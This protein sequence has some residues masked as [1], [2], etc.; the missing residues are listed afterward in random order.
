MIFY[1]IVSIA[2]ALRVFFIGHHDL[3]AEEA[4]YWNY[5]MHLDWSY[6]DHPV[7]VALLI[8]LS[9]IL[10]GLTEF[11][12]RFPAFICWGIAMYYSYQWSEL[13]QRGCGPY[14]VLL[15]SILPFF[16][17]YSLIIT[18]D[19]PLIACWSA[20]LYYLYRALCRH[21]KRAW[22][23]AGIAIGLGL[24]SKYTMVLVIATT[25]LY[26]LTVPTARVWLRQK[27]PYLALGIIGLL[28]TP[29][30]YWNITHD[31]VSFAFQSTRR[32]QGEFHF[33]L[34]E[35]LGLL[36]CFL[37]PIGIMGFYKLFRNATHH[38]SLPL[39][40]I[41]MFQYFTCLPLSVFLFFSIT[42]DI[43]S[44][45]IGPSLLG[46]IPWLAILMHHHARTVQCWYQTGVLLIIGYASLLFCMTFGQPK[47]INQMIL[48][49]MISWDNLT[50][51]I[52]T[53][54]TQIAIAQQEQPIIIPLD[55][56]SIASEL[57][58][59]QAKLLQHRPQQPAFPIY[60]ADPLGYNSLMF[61]YWYPYPHLQNKLV[62][63]I[64][65]TPDA[66]RKQRFITPVSEIKKI[67]GVSQ[68]ELAQIRTYYYQVARMSFTAA[69]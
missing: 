63:L 45:W 48:S 25:G 13:I 67:W 40:S 61:Q 9:T 3:L 68:G 6:L 34:H 60:G 64:G 31:W 51:Q 33:S 54:A 38:T 15:L 22:Y 58:F 59:Y 47:L 53:L 32:F 37:T 66:L 5:A 57:T 29:V 39:T 23:Y 14:S 12:V 17:L 50:T 62:I 16:F 28:F 42:R 21:Q 52:Y 69:S 41:R 35:L 65:K 30:I 4:Y 11:G 49:K 26:V 46:I 27:E 19:L 2:L 24:L 36:G 56:Y 10:F 18:P 1:S 20:A 7:M 43:K 55:S 44:N 8:K